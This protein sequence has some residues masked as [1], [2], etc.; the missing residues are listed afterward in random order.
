MSQVTTKY[1]LWVDDDF[2]F[3]ARTRLEKLVDV[4]ERTPLDLVGRGAECGPE[5]GLPGHAAAG[6]ASPGRSGSCGACACTVRGA[7]RTREAPYSGT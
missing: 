2:V 6:E 5:Q 4:L 7:G 3:T 1:V